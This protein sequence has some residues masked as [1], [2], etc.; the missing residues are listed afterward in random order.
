MK[1]LMKA[2]HSC[3]CCKETL[4]VALYIQK[5]FPG[6]FFITVLLQISLAAFIRL[7]RRRM[8]M[9]CQSMAG[10][11]CDWISSVFLCHR[12][13]VLLQQDQFSSFW[14]VF[15]LLKYTRQLLKC[16]MIYMSVPSVWVATCYLLTYW[17]APAKRK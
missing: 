7:L 2:L 3:S 12:E 6:I 11:M 1:P 16:E 14:E 5:W 13:D 8:Q 9:F 17:S 15:D 10:M 4:H